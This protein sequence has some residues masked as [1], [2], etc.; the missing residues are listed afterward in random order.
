MTFLVNDA[1][2]L[3]DWSDRFDNMTDDGL[4]HVFS[5]EDRRLYA[6]CIGKKGLATLIKC[7]ANASQI[8]RS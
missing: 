1:L 3:T 7:H 4:F 6:E 2:T 8:P 5:D